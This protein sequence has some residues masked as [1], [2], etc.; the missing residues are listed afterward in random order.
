[1]SMDT[2]AGHLRLNDTIF[3]D[4]IRS[5]CTSY[6]ISILCSIMYYKYIM[7][8]VPTTVPPVSQISIIRHDISPEVSGFIIVSSC[9]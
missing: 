5:R 4:T 1:M 3:N 6:T 9:Y 8:N 2:A 7:W